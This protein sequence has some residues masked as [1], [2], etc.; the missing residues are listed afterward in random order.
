[1]G[2]LVTAQITRYKKQ[3]EKEKKR[4][5]LNGYIVCSLCRSAPHKIVPRNFDIRQQRVEMLLQEARFGTNLFSW[6]CVELFPG[7]DTKEIS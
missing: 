1:L 7:L 3:T 4:K 6:Q 5:T 2:W